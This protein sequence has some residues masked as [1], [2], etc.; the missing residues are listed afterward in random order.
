VEAHTSILILAQVISASK[1]NSGE[2]IFFFSK[3]RVAVHY[4]AWAQ[5]SSHKFED[6][7]QEQHPIELVLGKGATTMTSLMLYSI[8]L[9]FMHFIH[10][11]NKF[12]HF[13]LYAIMVF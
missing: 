10:Q 12:K 11:F 4:R 8:L 9:C 5:G 6:T 13:T 7:W 3:L 2:L 1:E